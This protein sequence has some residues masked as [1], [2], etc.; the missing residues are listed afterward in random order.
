MRKTVGFILLGLA[1]FLVTAA[2]LVLVY[3]PGQVEKTPLDVN[4]TTRL[5]GEAAALPS[6]E[7]GP[8][9]A[10][11]RAVV[12][13]EA[14]DGDV[15]VFDTF[16]CLMRDVPGAADC[17]QDT[18][19]GSPLVTAGTD[20][21]ATDRR[22]GEAVNDEKYVGATAEPHEGVVN[23]WPFHP[24]QETY[25]YWDSLLKRGVDAAFVEE[26]EID[27]LAV[28]KYQ[29]SVVDE[30]AEISKGIAGLYS[31]EKALWV[32]KATGAIVDQNDKQVRKLESGTTV[33]DIDFGF[34]DET[35]AANVEDA[36]A[37]ASQLALV[38]RAPILLGVLGLLALVGGLFLARSGGSTGRHDS[39]TSL[40]ELSSSR[41]GR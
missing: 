22:T 41:R 5:S 35:V 20:R 28:Y 15:A 37:N 27:G 32:D 38:G 11:S 23:K 8:V 16:S 3:V 36:K 4:S 17:T 25:T 12:D 31:S 39:T 13:G 24:E 30:P 7:P 33:L 14:S 21:F 40:D 29:V 19:A 34:T 26:D 9:R 2:V 10:V 1:G 6:G 18:A